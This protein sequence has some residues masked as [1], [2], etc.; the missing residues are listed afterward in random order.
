MTEIQRAYGMYVAPITAGAVTALICG[1][2]N[3]EFG[4]AMVISMVAGVFG[5]AGAWL[6]YRHAG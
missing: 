1:M 6:A 5:G 2:A 4:T 3:V